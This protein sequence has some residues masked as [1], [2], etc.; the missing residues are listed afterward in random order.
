M[1][2]TFRNAT[3]IVLLLTS[4]AVA[5]FDEQEELLHRSNLPHDW[6]LTIVGTSSK[7]TSCA[8]QKIFDA[9]DDVTKETGAKTVKFLLMTDSEN[10]KQNY[11]F[12]ISSQQ[13]STTHGKEYSINFMVPGDETAY[14]LQGAGVKQDGS[15]WVGVH[16]NVTPSFLDLIAEKAEIAF[17]IAKKW[18]GVYN[19]KG[20]AVAVRVL[21]QCESKITSAPSGD[22][23]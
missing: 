13:W 10:P 1:L 6:I 21:K 4:P 18:I 9:S 7:A 11:G 16:T 5:Q 19:L 3:A 20:S 15:P 17:S 23:F 12:S 2:K 8:I 14:Q 22:T